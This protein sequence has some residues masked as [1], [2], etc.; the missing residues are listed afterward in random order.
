VA[1]PFYAGLTLAAGHA[2]YQL[3]LIRHQDLDASFLA[4]RS[5]N[6]FGALIFL[7]IVLATAVA[8]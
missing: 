7:A 6:V 1:W 3:W 8:P 5:N 4:F 2:L